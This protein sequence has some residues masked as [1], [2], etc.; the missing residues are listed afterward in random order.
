MYV[1][2][3]TG[4]QPTQVASGP[5]PKPAEPMFVSVPPRTQ[6]LLHS[7]AYLRYISYRSII[8]NITKD[9]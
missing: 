9:Y 6:R 1:M 7:D 8:L 2:V 4:Q 3:A 5:P